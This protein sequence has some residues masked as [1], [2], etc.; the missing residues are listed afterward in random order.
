[1]DVVGVGIGTGEGVADDVEGVREALVVGDVHIDEELIVGVGGEGELEVCLAFFGF[2]AAA[3][4][5][6]APGFGEGV[7]DAGCFLE[8]VARVADQVEEVVVDLGEEAGGADFEDGFDLIDDVEGLGLGVDIE[9]AGFLEVS[10]LRGGDGQFGEGG[11]GFCG[12]LGLGLFG[13]EQEGF[14]QFDAVVWLDIDEALFAVVAVDVDDE[15]GGAEGESGDF[16]EEDRLAGELDV[17][18]GIEAA[19]AVIV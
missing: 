17:V 5:D 2:E 13:I 16:G 11:M 18:G 6:S 4:F 10:E 7:A 8:G 1:M 19:E 12:E 15:V 3:G 9:E 14:S